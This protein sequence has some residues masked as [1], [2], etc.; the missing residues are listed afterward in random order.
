[1]G[2][3]VDHTG[4]VFG[5][6]TVIKDLGPVSRNTNRGK[7]YLCRCVCGTTKPVSAPTLV[8]GRSRGC[9]KCRPMKHG[10]ARSR[11]YKLC[12]IAKSRAK[13]AGIE[14]TLDWRKIVIPKTCPLLEIPI[15]FTHRRFCSTN[16]SIDRKDPAKGY[17]PENTWVVSWRANVIKHDATLEELE[18]IVQN[19]KKVLRS[20]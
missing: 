15:A 1:M 20:E 19:F 14:F 16:P 11:V 12:S 2:K 8:S 5:K 4:K 13:K 7:R 3:L 9:L 18:K 6:W 17:T 10:Q